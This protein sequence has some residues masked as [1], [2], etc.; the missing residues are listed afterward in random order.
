MK[1]PGKDYKPFKQSEDGQKTLPGGATKVNPMWHQPF[2]VISENWL[3]DL[4]NKLAKLENEAD[5]IIHYVSLLP[6]SDG[7]GGDDDIVTRSIAFDIERPPISFVTVVCIMEK[8]GDETAK[9][10]MSE[11]KMKA[12]DIGKNAVNS[13]HD[14]IGGSR[15]NRRKLIAYWNSGNYKS[16]ADC[17]RKVCDKCGLTETVALRVLYSLPKNN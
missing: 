6:K 13:R 11:I 5:S 2:E 10:I 17:A 3:N 12:S 9:K 4:R 15:D 16:K 14:Q 7:K 1:V 8:L